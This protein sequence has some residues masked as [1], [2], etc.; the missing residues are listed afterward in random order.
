MTSTQRVCL[1]VSERKRGDSYWPKWWHHLSC[2]KM[3]HKYRSHD[4]YNWI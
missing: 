3:V 1:Q 4:R 2:Y